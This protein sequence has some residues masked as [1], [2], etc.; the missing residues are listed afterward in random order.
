MHLDGVSQVTYARSMKKQ[1]ITTGEAA[2]LLECSQRTVQ[3]MIE[4]KVLPGWKI[5]PGLKSVYMVY[6]SD[7]EEILR[8]RKA[9]AR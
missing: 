9:L 1:S 7:V 2:I 5:T 8:Q 6:K 4:K 3:R